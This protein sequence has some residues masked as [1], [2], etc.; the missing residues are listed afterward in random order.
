MVIELATVESVTLPRNGEKNGVLEE[1]LKAAEGK[2][3]LIDEIASFISEALITQI[4]SLLL[5]K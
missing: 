1:G 2:L 5:I 3:L 4:I